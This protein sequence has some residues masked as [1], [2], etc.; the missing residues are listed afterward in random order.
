MSNTEERIGNLLLA[1]SIISCG[2]C[3]MRPDF[4]IVLGL[5]SYYIWKTEIKSKA[6]LQNL[7][8]MNAVGLIFD[9]IWLLLVGRLWLREPKNNGHIWDAMKHMHYFIL[10][11]SLVNMCVRG[12][13]LS[14]I[15]QMYEQDPNA[16]PKLG[17]RTATGQRF[18]E[19][20]DQQH[21]G[22]Q[23]IGGYDDNYD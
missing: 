15:F 12:Y 19:H 5:V 18:I 17:S 16:P 6:V 11:L 2:C 1:G 10:F 14:I 22:E 20:R 23:Y 21:P 8:L 13:A 4:N 9:L 3:L 7:L